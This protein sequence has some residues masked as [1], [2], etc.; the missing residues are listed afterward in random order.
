MRAKK[1]ITTSSWESSYND[2]A[3]IPDAL[4][5]NKASQPLAEISNWLRD[6]FSFADPLLALNYAG[7]GFWLQALLG[8]GVLWSLLVKLLMATPQDLFALPCISG[9]EVAGV[10]DAHLMA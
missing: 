1:K 2:T 8:V 6:G 10:S 3:M 9:W 7:A 5:I 4:I